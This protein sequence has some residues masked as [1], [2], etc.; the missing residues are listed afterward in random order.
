MI[1]AIRTVKYGKCFTAS[2]FPS[3]KHSLEIAW[4]NKPH[5]AGEPELFH[6]EAM[7]TKTVFLSSKALPPLGA[8]PTDYG[9]PSSSSH[10]STKPVFALAL[11]ILRLEGTLHLF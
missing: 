5:R 1:Q 3:R 2:S 6:A 9:A 7:Y 10:P 4:D 11:Q 8:A